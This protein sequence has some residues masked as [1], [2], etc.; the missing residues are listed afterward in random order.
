MCMWKLEVDVWCLPPLL[1]TLYIETRSFTWT[2][3]FWF[4]S[5]R[6]LLTQGIPSLP[7]YSGITSRLPVSWTWGGG[8]PV[9]KL[10][11]QAIYPLSHLP[12]WHWPSWYNRQKSIKDMGVKVQTSR[13]RCLGAKRSQKHRC[14]VIIIIVKE[15]IWLNLLSRLC[16]EIKTK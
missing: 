16:L 12:A 2:Q 5:P 8:S 11:K 7:P 1:S 9:P 3:S 6:L 14:I 13:G 10:V 4:V 15:L